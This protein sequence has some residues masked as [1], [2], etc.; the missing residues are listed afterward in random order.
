MFQIYYKIVIKQNPT[1]T[2]QFQMK[3]KFIKGIPC[4]A[5]W[6]PCHCDSAPGIRM[7]VSFVHTEISNKMQQCI[8]IYY[9]IIIRSSTCL[10]RHTTHHREPKTALVTSGF[11]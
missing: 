1:F 7:R 10:G 5:V 2:T 11:A 8:K 4:L 9:S 3:P 6:A